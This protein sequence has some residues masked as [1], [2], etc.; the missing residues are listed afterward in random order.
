MVVVITAAIF[1]IGFMFWNW[2]GFMT[3]ANLANGAYDF[4]S[5]GYGI[6]AGWG[7]VENSE[8]FELLNQI[9]ERH[10][11]FSPENV[12]SLEDPV[13]F[14]LRPP[15]LALIVAGINRAWGIRADVPIQLL[16]ILLDT[17][18]AGLTF[19]IGR[20]CLGWKVGF[21]SGLIY[22]LCLP[23][24]YICTIK[25]ACGFVSFFVVSFLACLLQAMWNRGERSIAWLILAGIAVGLGSYFRPDYLLVPLFTFCGVWAYTHRFWRSVAAM[26]TVQIIALFVLF[27]WAYRNNQ[28]FGRWIFTSTSVGPTLITGL[29][30]FNNPWGFYGGDNIRA[31]QAQEVGIPSP[32][33]SE[34]DL[35]FR[36]LFWS[37]VKNNPL[38]YIKIVMKRIPFSLATPFWWGYDNPYKTAFY[39]TRVASAPQLPR[40]EYLILHWKEA[41][42]AH[43]HFA[44]TMF[45]TL[46]GS[47]SVIILFVKEW[48]HAGLILLLVSPHL[49]SIITH[50]LTHYEE[51][52]L[53]PSLFCWILALGYVLAKGWHLTRD[54]EIPEPVF[55]VLKEV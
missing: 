2:S 35:Y 12:A 27:P 31:A 4:L 14:G 52:F 19:Y 41:I 26:A 28:V 48:S 8:T 50:T 16:G 45:F 24:A 7:Y 29:A 25:I 11:R 49:Y 38:S 47:F 36:K 6:A 33:R 10:I 34:S 18:A 32:W 15:G 46:A 37:S 20:A 54:T 5:T 13:P 30:E 55:G 22:A 1:R 17:F 51:R 9:E 3:G 21:V 44:L 23:L 39:E 40:E 42:P 43:W 53:L